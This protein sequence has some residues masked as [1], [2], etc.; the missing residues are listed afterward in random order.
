ML[1]TKQSSHHQALTR[2]AGLETQELRMEMGQS[3]LVGLVS[4]DIWRALQIF[5]DSLK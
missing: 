3:E 5:Y 2:G 1:E 4:D